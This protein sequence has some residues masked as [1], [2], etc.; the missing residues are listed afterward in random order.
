ML[1][2]V[3]SSR[4]CRTASGAGDFDLVKFDSEV[5]GDGASDKA[6]GL[7][8]SNIVGMRVRRVLGNQ[9]VQAVNGLPDTGEA[10]S[11]FDFEGPLSI[12]ALSRCPTCERDIQYLGPKAEIIEER[13]AEQKQGQSEGSWNPKGS[14]EPTQRYFIQK[15]G[16][17]T[18]CTPKEAGN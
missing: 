15:W 18:L 5:S 16:Q 3:S 11:G 13:R 4:V 7:L 8:F 9:F 2:H 17:K 14:R 12:I 10:G 6:D 1:P